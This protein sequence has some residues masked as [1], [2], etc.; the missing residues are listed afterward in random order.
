MTSIVSFEIPGVLRIFE[1]SLQEL[2]ACYSVTGPN[3]EYSKNAKKLQG[4][5]EV[6]NRVKKNHKLRCFE[7]G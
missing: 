7:T 5:L 1:V 3:L 4:A 2:R 6:T